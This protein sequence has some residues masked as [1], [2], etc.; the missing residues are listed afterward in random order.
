MRTAHRTAVALSALALAG[1]LAGCADDAE[2]DPSPAD[3]IGTS[4][5]IPDEEPSLIPSP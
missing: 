2:T 3:P 5:L 1:A 4:P